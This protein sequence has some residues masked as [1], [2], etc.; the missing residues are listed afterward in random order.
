VTLR[1]YYQNS[2]LRE[3]DAQVLSVEPAP[4]PSGCAP[5]AQQWHVVLDRTVFYPTSGG[6]PH[7]TGKLADASVLDVFERHDHGVV[8]V[9]GRVFEIGAEVI[10]AAGG[11]G[12]GSKDFGQGSIANVGA[13]ETVLDRASERLRG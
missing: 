6:Q 9:T 7:D 5:D 11:K 12:G 4:A 1:L 2:F 3:F 13:V 8:H 10:E